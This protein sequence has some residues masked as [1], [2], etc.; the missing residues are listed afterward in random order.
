MADPGLI[1]VPVPLEVQVQH[2]KVLNMV[3]EVAVD[4]QIKQELQVVVE[5][6][7]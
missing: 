1:L 5:L 4:H 2:G 6:L 7:E 3:T